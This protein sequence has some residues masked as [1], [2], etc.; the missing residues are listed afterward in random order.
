M[1]RCR[2]YVYADWKYGLCNVCLLGYG[3]QVKAPW[4]EPL[5]SERYRLRT[6]LPLGFGWRILFFKLRTIPG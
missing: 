3:F 6:V 4:L 1:K 2:T 5:F